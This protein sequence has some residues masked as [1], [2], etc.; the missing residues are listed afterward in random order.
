MNQQKLEREIA[1]VVTRVLPLVRKNATV[2]KKEFET[3]HAE[4]LRRVHD[5]T[6]T[7]MDSIVEKV[8][9]VLK[10]LPSEYGCLPE[11]QRSW[12]TLIG[13]LYT[14]YLKELGQL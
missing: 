2:G 5:K 13:Y 11:D 12:E 1:Q 4:I 8:D 14:R 6:K 3:I 9:T 10:A 7:S